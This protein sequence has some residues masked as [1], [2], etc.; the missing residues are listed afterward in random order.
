PA[1][2]DTSASRGG[3]FLLDGGADQV[4]PFGPRTVV[5]L[6]VVIAQQIFQHEPGVG[7]ALSDAAVGDYFAVAVHAFA[8]V[9]LLQGLG[10]FERAVLIR[11][12][13]PRNIRRARNV[14]GAL[15]RLRHSRRRDDLPGELIH[16]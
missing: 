7:A 8:A 11:R 10:G 12:L 3:R 2:R 15:R 13:R 14:T 4:A 6:H 1:G 9:E 16:G 5:V